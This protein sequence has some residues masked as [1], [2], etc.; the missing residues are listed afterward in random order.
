MGQSWKRWTILAVAV[1]VCALL[2][3]R[4]V[5]RFANVRRNHTPQTAAESPQPAPGELGARLPDLTL[6]DVSGRVITP[7]DLAGKVLLIDYWATWCEPCKKEMPGYQRLQDK[8]QGR[9]LVVIGI[10]FDGTG[11]PVRGFAMQHGIRYPLVVNS[12]GME[13]QFGGILGLPTT[14]VFDRNHILRYKVI[15]FEYTDVVEKAFQ[16]LL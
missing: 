9:G 13:S 5:G 12:P 14:F 2:L 10:A 3:V 16:P 11:D 1:V 7:G 6:T 8:Y 15:G 4:R